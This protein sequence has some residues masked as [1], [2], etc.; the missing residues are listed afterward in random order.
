MRIGRALKALGR[1]AAAAICNGLCGL[2]QDAHAQSPEISMRD[3]SSA[4]IKKGVRSIGFGGDGATWGNYGLVWKDANTALLDYGNTRFDNGNTFQFSAVG[5]TSPA[6]WHGLAIYVIAMTQSAHDIHFRDKSPAFGSTAVPVSGSGSDHAIF[7][8]IAM[9]LGH[10]IS[11]GVLLAHETS[12]LDATQTGSQA[13]GVHYETH[14]SPSGGFG[15][16]WQPDKTTIV[17]ARVL[18]N[19][20]QEQ[21]TD[22]RSVTQGLARSTELRLG[23]STAPWSEALLDLGWTH[24]ERHSGLSGVSSTADHPNVGF[25]QGFSHRRY[26]VRL[27][28][29]ETSP[30]LGFSYHRKPAHFDLAYVHDM[31]RARVGQLFGDHSRSFVMTFTLDYDELMRVR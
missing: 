7:S 28:V 2:G 6:L 26:I 27:G 11:A 30:T 19:D 18:V 3:F 13:Q 24:L 1:L 31:A 10:G 17:G 15:V 5:L 21:R 16:A 29:D 23:G 4:Q 20:D 9:P 22:A 12:K 8:K 14:W 25:E